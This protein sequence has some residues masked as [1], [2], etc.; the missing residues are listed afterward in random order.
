[1]RIIDADVLMKNIGK[2]PQLRGITYGRMK[3]A[4]EETPTIDAE[5]VRHGEWKWVFNRKADTKFG[6][7]AYESGWECSECGGRATVYISYEKVDESMEKQEMAI[8]DERTPYCHMCGAKM[9][10]GLPHNVGQTTGGAEDA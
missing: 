6:K 2:I 9:D 7:D 4:V 10:G 8:T 1:M 5:P 3:R